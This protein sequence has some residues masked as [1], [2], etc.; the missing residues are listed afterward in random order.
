MR[1]RTRSRGSTLIEFAFI[2]VTLLLVMFFAI[3]LDRM[4]FVY[5]CLSDAAK[6]GAR[7][8]ITHGNNRGGSGVNG[9][10]GPGADPPQVVTAVTNYARLMINPAA[11]TV[12]VSYPDASNTTGSRVNVL[13]Q[14]AYDPYTLLPLKVTLSATSQGV[15]T[16]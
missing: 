12:T 3:E 15:I 14:Y 6:A 4:L 8:A 13:V 10:S 9:P 2:A 5:T 11:L 7:Y 16:F 1:H